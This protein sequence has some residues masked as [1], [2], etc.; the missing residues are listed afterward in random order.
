MRRFTTFFFLSL[1][2]CF[3]ALQASAAGNRIVAIVNDHVITQQA[4]NHAII[5]AQHMA[6][7]HHQAL[8]RGRELHQMILNQLI[9]QRLVLDFAKD[10]EITVTTKEVAR[11][12]ARVAQQQKLSV[13]QY[14]AKMHKIG[15]SGERLD[16]KM[17][18]QLLLIK[19]Q[20][21]V[22]GPQ[23]TISDAQIKQLQEQFAHQQNRQ[24]IHL[25]DLK[26]S[27]PDNASP[28]QIKAAIRYAQHL[29]QKAIKNKDNLASLAKKHA[30]STVHFTDLGTLTPNQIPVLYLPIVARLNAQ[31]ISN[32]ISAPNGVHL[33]QR[34]GTATKTLSADQARDILRQRQFNETLETW[35]DTLR[36]EA[37]VKIMSAP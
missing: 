16:K 31:Q 26:F 35:V 17:R 9:S 22:I 11:F 8:P 28:E 5:D 4:L 6:K 36:A 10:H 21:L 25:L 20:Q 12:T 18:D 23:I 1:L 24:H 3:S 29:R 32:P 27:L 7:A 19:T 14:R 37:Y 2:I 13:A 33:I 15:I 34:L 30:S